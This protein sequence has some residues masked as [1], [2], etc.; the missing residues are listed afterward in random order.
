MWHN[1]I[2]GYRLGI[3]IPGLIILTVSLAL[4]LDSVPIL[5]E[6]KRPPNKISKMDRID[7]A[8]EQEFEMTKD[9]KL[10][11]V[12]RQRLFEVKKIIFFN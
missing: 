10:N 11:I 5:N 4:L 1:P 2:L 9:P 8:M 7:L 3:R 12:P 6:G